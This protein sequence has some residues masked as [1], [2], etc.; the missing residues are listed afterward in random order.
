MNESTL[1][2][3]LFI[4]FEG[5]D[6]CGK[7]T[8]ARLFAQ[9]LQDQGHPTLTLRDP[10]S[11]AISERIRAILLDLSHKEMSSYTEL[12]L[13]EA[14]RAQ[15]VEQMI[16]PA[17]SSGQLVVCDRFFDSTTAYQGY[18]REL[19][20]AVIRQANELGSCGL[21]PHITFLIDLEPELALKR[22]R[23]SNRLKDRMEAEGL[24]FQNR[25]RNGFMTIAHENPQRIMVLRGDQSIQEIQQQIRLGFER[26]YNDQGRSL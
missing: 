12:L 5:I 14:A 26:V 15:M 8:Q 19:D 9:Y 7:S 21:T 18:G 10:G 23:K 3:G 4:T 2:Q 17:L 22:R 16:R 6:F 24:D 25:V 13:Y 11:S 20:L 1:G